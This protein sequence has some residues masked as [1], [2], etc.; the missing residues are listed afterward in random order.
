MI[1]RLLPETGGIHLTKL[2]GQLLKTVSH[3]SLIS[4]HRKGENA[5]YLVEY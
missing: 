1:M 4:S 2:N 3:S 5:S